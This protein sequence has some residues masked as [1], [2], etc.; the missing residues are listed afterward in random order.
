MRFVASLTVAVGC[1]L[2]IAVHAQ[3]RTT[4]TKTEV[5]GDA[6]TIT[7]SGCVRTGTEAQSFIL[8]KIVPVGQTTEVGTSGSVTTTTTYLLV[9]GEKIAF[10]QYVGHKVEVTGMMMPA[11]DS[12][13]ETRT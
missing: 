6:K 5:K 3:D 12:K 11:G 4:T 9:P 13:T 2:A 8:D 7:Y 1:A 10:Q